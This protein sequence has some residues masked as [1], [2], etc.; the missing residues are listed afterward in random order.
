M[1]KPFVEKLLRGKVKQLGTE[2]ASNPMDRS[3]ESAIFKET[4]EETILLTQTGLVG[5]E[6]ADTKNHGGPDKAIFAYASKHYDYWKKELANESIGIGANGENLAVAFMD[7]DSVCLGDTYQFGQALFQVS[8][9]RQPCWKPAR[10]FRVMDF[11]LQIQKTGKTG[12]YFRVLEEGLV[13]SG[14]E[15]ALIE[16]PYPQ[17]TITKCN[18]IMHDKKAD[19]KLTEDLASCPLLA[20]SWQATLNKRVAGKK[21]SIDERVFGPNQD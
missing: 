10:R 6:V 7:E 2:N 4:V 1:K 17:W 21:S 12:W 15:L 11:A 9:P 18:D 5:D 20:E 8:Q 13:K 19:L 16:R 14:T 3:W